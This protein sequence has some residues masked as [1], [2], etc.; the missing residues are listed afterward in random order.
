M[1]Y[2]ATA[3]PIVPV[4]SIMPATVDV[5]DLFFPLPLPISALHV[6]AIVLLT[7]CKKNPNKKNKKHKLV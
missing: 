3:D 6:D 4:P 1:V 2:I 5:T 7:L